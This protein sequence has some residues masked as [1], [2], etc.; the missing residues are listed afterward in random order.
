MQEKSSSF[1][2]CKVLITGGLG[3]IGSNLA[4][5]LAELGTQEILVESLIPEDGG[6]LFSIAR[7][8]D[9]VRAR[10]MEVPEHGKVQPTQVRLSPRSGMLL[11]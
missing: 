9:K 8:E 7:I 4:R 11:F 1:A 5:R 10:L 2:N 3:F 6:N